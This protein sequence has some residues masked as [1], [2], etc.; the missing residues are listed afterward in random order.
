MTDVQIIFEGVELRDVSPRAKTT[1]AGKE[2]ELVGN[3][4]HVQ[5]P[6]VDLFKETFL[7]YT[8]DY[9]D[10]VAIKA[11]RRIFGRLIVTDPDDPI[12]IRNVAISGE[13]PETPLAR[14]WEYRVTFV[15]VM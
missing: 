15:Q 3:A 13:I 1:V 12:D 10:I 6:T 14:G 11:K 5:F 9:A 4:R 2:T 8:Q 7:C